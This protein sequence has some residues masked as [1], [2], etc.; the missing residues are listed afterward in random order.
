M[1][2]GYLQEG[3][4]SIIEIISKSGGL[5]EDLET[6]GLDSALSFHFLLAL[7][8]LESVPHLLHIEII[9]IEQVLD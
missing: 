5:R 3:L 7:L 4:G 8:L 2:L 6:G 9:A 1:K